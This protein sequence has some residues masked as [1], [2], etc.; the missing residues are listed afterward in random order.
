VVAV[1]RYCG[2]CRAE[3]DAEDVVAES[4]PTEV[5]R[6]PRCGERNEFVSRKRLA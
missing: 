2:A 6:C 1:S 4:G 5:Y 3:L